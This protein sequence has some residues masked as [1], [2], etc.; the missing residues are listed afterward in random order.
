MAI[1]IVA[2]Q[3]GEEVREDIYEFDKNT[4]ISVMLGYAIDSW[5]F[6][7]PYEEDRKL[8]NEIIDEEWGGLDGSDYYQYKKP[9]V[10]DNK[11]VTNYDGYFWDLQTAIN[12]LKDNIKFLTKIK[13]LYGG[14]F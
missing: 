7:I 10:F 2:N 9:F 4:D 11:W 8:W 12:E 14:Q 5:A 1:I 13:N 6:R 3:Y